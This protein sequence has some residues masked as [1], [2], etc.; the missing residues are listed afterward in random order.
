MA[1]TY[2][3][4]IIGGGPGGYVAAIRAAQLGFKTAVV[5]RE[6]L[7]GICLNW[8]CIPTK[9]LLRSAEV[10]HYAEHGDNYGLKIQ[11]P[12]FDIAAVVKRSRGVS[13]QLNGG[14][15]GLMKKN[16]IDVIWGQAKLTKAG[17]G[18]PVEVEV[19]EPTKPA[20]QPQNPVPKGVLGHGTYKAKHV[21]VATGARPRVLPGIEADGERIWTYFEAMKP[22]TMPKSLI[23]MG[24]GAI[25]IE[26]ASFYRTMGAEVTV[27]ELLPQILPV[28]DAEIAAV[29]R[30]QFE[31]QGMKILSDAK[32]AKVS[33]TADGV[34]V[35]VEQG[36]KSQVLKAEKLIS[37]V[38]VQGNTEGLNLEGVGVT[39]ERGL[40]KTDPYGRTNVEG[41]YAIGDVAGAPM[42]AHKAEHEGTICI[43]KI[44]GM[45]AH[46]MKRTQIPGCTYCQPQIASVGL[47]EAKAKE[48]GR[49]V[50]VGRFRFLANGKA[51]ALG[52]PDGMVKT[53]FDAK[54]G[55][56]LG[57]H[58]VGAEVTELIQG[59]VIA[60]GLETTE[61]ELMHTVFPHPT[62]SE[63]MH[64]SVLDA[65]GKVIHM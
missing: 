52:E 32:V 36:G 49:E 57:A 15:A 23:V 5:E 38:G 26:F 58:M 7:G 2:D 34:E 6:H 59:F 62:L 29:A 28:E 41:V 21:I 25:G 63:M 17:K 56:L 3:I 8:G 10:F 24:S 39:V 16:K 18:G 11:K 60:M 19:G 45:D 65:Y 9:A 4:L 12:D 47:T 22:Q 53:V 1:D 20:V 42:L 14:V 31:K 30:K 48:E 44:K 35:T 13:A 61:E 54:T 33:K 43:E 40:V 27:V 37:A 50:K 64:E 51:I 55:E 46:P